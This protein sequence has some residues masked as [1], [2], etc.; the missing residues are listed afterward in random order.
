MEKITNRFIDFAIAAYLVFVFIDNLSINLFYLLTKRYTSKLL[1]L[2]SDTYFA[3]NNTIELY[4]YKFFLIITI[5][6]SYYYLFHSF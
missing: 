4:E 6:A 2:N 5:V 3:A 1:V